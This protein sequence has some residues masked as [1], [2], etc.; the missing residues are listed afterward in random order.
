[1]ARTLRIL[2]LEDNPADAELI[3]EALRRSG[4]ACEIQL[5]T[6]YGEY[7]AAL[8]Q[9]TPD[10]IL[11]DSRGHDFEG[12]AVLRQVRRQFP[13]VPFLFLSGSYQGKDTAALKA[14]G[15][16]E[17]LLKDDLDTLAAAIQHA[18]Q[19]GR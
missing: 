7:L 1:M 4:L 8:R 17:C 14:E 18:L 5:A 15:A 2:H 19:D 16:A 10:L 6:S 11:S 3:R 12:L 13:Q 9:G